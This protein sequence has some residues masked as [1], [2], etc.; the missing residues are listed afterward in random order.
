MP[1][2]G[3]RRI[4]A[5]A[6]ITLAALIIVTGQL[7][8]LQVLE[9]PRLSELSDR[10]RVRARPL[11]APRGTLYDR[12]GVPLVETRPSFALSIVPR[13]L[14]DRG[15]VL[16]RLSI[17]LKLPLTELQAAL[18]GLTADSEWPVRI[19][20]DL[21]FEDVVRIEEW[22]SELP[23]VVVEVEPRR[24][25]VS[26]RFAAH[27]LGYVR[28]ASPR[29]VREGRYRPGDLVGQSGLEQLLDEFLRGRD[30]GEYVE[31][32]AAGRPVRPL[33]REEPRADANV[34]STVDRRIQQAAE[35]ALGSP[36]GA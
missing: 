21:S 32:D 11:A 24:D 17:L 1:P 2:D 12:H 19:R 8:Y 27:L 28:E 34:L 3:P 23:G 22:R 9:G 31:V 16:A 26:S 35:Q 18:D 6:G 25:Y 20:R 7:W 33:R 36:P 30:G 13:E 29:Q 4:R 10:K 14:T 5:L 15:A